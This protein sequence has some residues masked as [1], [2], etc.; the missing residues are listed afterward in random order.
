MMFEEINQ[1]MLTKIRKFRS[2]VLGAIGKL[3]RKVEQLYLEVTKVANGVI[4]PQLLN[5]QEIRKF[6]NMTGKNSSKFELILAT[7]KIMK[8]ELITGNDARILAHI[9]I[10]M[11][12][13]LEEIASYMVWI[14]YIWKELGDASIPITLGN[15]TIIFIALVTLSVSYCRKKTRQIKKKIREQ[16]EEYNQIC[17]QISVEFV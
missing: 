5:P 13:D 8:G 15:S 1:R 4:T 7:Y 2:D 6:T 14:Q 12:S 16:G 9:P 11:S 3:D 17:N 10:Q